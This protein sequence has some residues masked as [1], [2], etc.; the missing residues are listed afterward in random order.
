LRV[1]TRQL[2]NITNVTTFDGFLINGCEPL[3]MHKESSSPV[4]G[5]FSRME[6]KKSQLRK[7]EQISKQ[8]LDRPIFFPRGI[9]STNT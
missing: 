4:F 3:I 7:R 6:Q 9:S 2:G 5:K 8:L 1:G